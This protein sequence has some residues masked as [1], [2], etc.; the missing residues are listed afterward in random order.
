MSIPTEIF[1]LIDKYCSPPYVYQLYAI[2]TDI[3]YPVGLNRVPIFNIPEK[4]GDCEFAG[5]KFF[6]NKI[7]LNDS[8]SI[9]NILGP[10]L[11]NQR[12][13]EYYFNGI[14]EELKILLSKMTNDNNENDKIAE[15]FNKLQNKYLYM[16][17]IH[18]HMNFQNLDNYL[19]KL[20]EGI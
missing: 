13:K 6:I 3:I 19:E 18:G 8:Y 17:K 12:P 11:Y 7:F 10:G 1:D 5:V 4:H 2:C 14:H 15:K 20:K 9:I 16:I